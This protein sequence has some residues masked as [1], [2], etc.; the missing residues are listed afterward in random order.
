[1]ALASCAV[2]DG[3]CDTALENLSGKNQTVADSVKA[4][5]KSETWS[6]IADTLAGAWDGNW[7]NQ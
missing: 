6:T 1:M 7:E 4:L 5:M 3:Y 2:R